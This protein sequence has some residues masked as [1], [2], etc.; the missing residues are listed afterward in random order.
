MRRC[1][2]LAC[3][4]AMVSPTF[5]AKRV[6][7]EQLQQVLSAIHSKP[8]ADIAR[9]LSDLQLT[10]RL[11]T[12][13]L[14]QLEEDFPGPEAQQALTALADLSAFLSLPPAEIPATAAPDFC[15]A[16]PDDG[17]DHNL[18]EQDAPSAA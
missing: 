1:V 16:A 12:A 7:V 11:S 14:L 2:L 18:C 6:T 9:Q 3:L 10:E 4:A 17:P 13:R 8:D 5:A 15:R